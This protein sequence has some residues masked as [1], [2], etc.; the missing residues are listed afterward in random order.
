MAQALLA[1]YFLQTDV[2]RGC[3]AL[4]KVPGP[5]LARKGPLIGLGIAKVGARSLDSGRLSIAVRIAQI[6]ADLGVGW[7]AI[8]ALALDEDTATR[9]NAMNDLTGGVFGSDVGASV[10][11]YAD[12]STEVLGAMTTA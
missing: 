11:R 4:A 12:W 1:S 2:V 9:L 10:V 6:V 3:Q 5:V 7:G 8:K